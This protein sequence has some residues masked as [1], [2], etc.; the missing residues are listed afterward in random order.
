MRLK[1]RRRIYETQ[2]NLDH[3]PVVRTNP[4]PRFHADV[5]KPVNRSAECFPRIGRAQGGARTAPSWANTDFKSKGQFLAPNLTLRTLSLQHFDGRGS[6]TS[7]DY[8][9]VG[10]EPPAEEWRATTGTY[11]I[12]PD[13]TGSASLAVDAGKPPLNYHLI[14]VGRGRQI[15]LV[16]GAAIRG[17]GSRIE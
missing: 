11:S 12:N 14:V 2:F 8:V 6:L 13:C 5:S 3:A 16:D 9:V 10:G 7:V 4:D 15:L 17:V 1:I